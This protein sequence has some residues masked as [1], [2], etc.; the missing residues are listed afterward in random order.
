[1]AAAIR[2]QLST[3]TLPYSI[4]PHIGFEDENEDDDENEKEA[5]NEIS[6]NSLGRLGRP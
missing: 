4:T 5:P 2:R 1:M 3:P 6:T